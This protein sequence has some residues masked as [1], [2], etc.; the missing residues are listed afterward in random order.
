MKLLN[1]CVGI[2]LYISGRIKRLS[3]ELF[4]FYVHLSYIYWGPVNVIDCTNGGIKKIR[5]TVSTFIEFSFKLCAYA[6]V[7]V[8]VTDP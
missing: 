6:C 3:G 4:Y 1:V 2:Y 5:D 8:C 7:C